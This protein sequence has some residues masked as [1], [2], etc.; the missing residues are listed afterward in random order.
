MAAADKEP[1]PD[2]TSLEKLPETDPSSDDEAKDPT[3]VTTGVLGVPSKPDEEQ[4]K[5]DDDS[6]AEP[7]PAR[8]GTG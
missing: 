8:K 5:A 1:A 3:C 2:L 4:D 7:E 6:K